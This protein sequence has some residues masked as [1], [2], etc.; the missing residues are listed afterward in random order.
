MKLIVDTTDARKPRIFSRACLPASLSWACWAES[1]Y[2]SFSVQEFCR[3]H[4]Q[5]QPKTMLPYD[6][7]IRGQIVQ[8]E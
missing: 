2:E 5:T 8:N 6:H 3:Q 1:W 7:Y 4:S